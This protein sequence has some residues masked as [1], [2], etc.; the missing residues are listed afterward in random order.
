M[1]RYSQNIITRLLTESDG[2]PN[3]D[4]KGAKL[5]ELVKYLFDKVPGVQ[6]YA[7]NTDAARQEA[8]AI[9]VRK[10]R[11]DA[12]AA[13]R[14]AGGTITGLLEINVG[15]YYAPPPRP[16]ELRAKGAMATTGAVDTPIT[17]GDQTV[18]VDIS[19]RW[20]FSAK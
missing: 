6:F 4:V 19:T 1:A 9:A 20:Q 8:I 18:A 2:A 7:S 3:A 10:A 16:I 17:A 12:D 13:A 11:S 15:S 14:A 5:E